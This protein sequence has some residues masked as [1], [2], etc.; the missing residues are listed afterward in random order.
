MQGL[1]L[2]GAVIDLEGG[3]YGVSKPVRFPTLGGGNVFIV[4]GSIKALPGFAGSEEG[5]AGGGT[6]CVFEEF[7]KNF[8]L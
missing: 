6:V 3:V 2:G 4:G 5:R 7:D 8:V 1:D